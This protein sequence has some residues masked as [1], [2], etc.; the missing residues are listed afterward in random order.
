MAFDR[1][2]K[3][4]YGRRVSETVQARETHFFLLNLILTHTTNKNQQLQRKI[5]LST[6]ACASSFSTTTE[7]DGDCGQDKGHHQDEGQHYED[8]HT[9]PAVSPS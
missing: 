3:R 5:G 4:C 9:R 7:G 8:D 6:G 1:R 2:H